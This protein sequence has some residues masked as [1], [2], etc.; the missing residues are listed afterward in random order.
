MPPVHS[1][2]VLREDFMKP[3]DLSV[4]K[5]ALEFARACDTHRRDRA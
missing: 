5:L 4:N 2:E 3:L 1:G